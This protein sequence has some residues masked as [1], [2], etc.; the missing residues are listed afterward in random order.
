[1]L[2]IVIWDVQHGSAAYIKTPNGKHIVI[3]LG[4]G[5]Y[6]GSSN[7]FSP[8]LHL[9][10]RYGI[11]TLDEVIITHPHT[12]H[13]DDIFNFESLNPSILTRPNHL[14]E[15]DIRN[16]NPGIHVPKVEKYI[17]INNRYNRELTGEE[18]ITLP[19][20]NGGVNISTFIPTSCARTNLNNHS[21]VTLIEYAGSKILIP[22][23]NESPSWK[24]LLENAN[25]N[26]A[27]KNTNIFVAPHHG[28]EAGYCA[29]L[30]NYF[31]P[32]LTVVSDGA[33]TDTSAVNRYS[34]ISR[35]W[36]VYKR[37]TDESFE[38]K[39]LTTRNDGIIVIKAGIGQN[40]RPYLNVSIG[41]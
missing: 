7:D 34:K 5:S 9:K 17:E 41:S 3:D 38:R 8:L 33:E 25:F 10:N 19:E 18:N 30:F 23:G 37:G 21:L 26:S 28:R 39:C 16:A 36:I 1:M 22:G 12:D 4:V 40:N 2:E 6:T 32:Y 20:N 11:N 29:E 31:S 13:I 27:I 14:T 35:G 24:T 15:E